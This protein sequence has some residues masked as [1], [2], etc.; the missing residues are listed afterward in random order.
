M[1]RCL[2]PD[3]PHGRIPP[4]KTPTKMT[5]E[6]NAKQ[7][8]QQ[9]Y[10]RIMVPDTE[11]NTFTAYIAEFPGCVVQG[12]SPTDAIVQLEE[13]AEA[14]VEASLANEQTIP[15]PFGDNE[16]SGKF[17]LRL[18]RTLHRESAQTAQREGVSLNQFFVY[19]ISQCVGA[20]GLYQTLATKIEHKIKTAVTDIRN[21]VRVEWISAQ[22]YGTS[23]TAVQVPTH[24]RKPMHGRNFIVELGN[25]SGVKHG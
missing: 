22:Y 7:Y 25:V 21:M 8:L 20:K 24:S 12:N 9:P 4:M 11:T 6:K 13:A 18:P 10:S 17:A 15:E 1:C 3:A 23:A 14:W 5:Q 19:A 2:R 16:Y